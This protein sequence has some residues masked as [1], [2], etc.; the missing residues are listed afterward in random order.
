MESD[1]SFQLTP[2]QHVIFESWEI[3]H[4]EQA[5]FNLGVIHLILLRLAGKIATE[6]VNF[7]IGEQVAFPR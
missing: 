6:S 3:Q 5:V 7:A 4:L 1:V 2:S